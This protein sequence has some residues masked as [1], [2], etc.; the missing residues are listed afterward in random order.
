MQHP[1]NFFNKMVSNFREMRG[2]TSHMYASNDIYEDAEES[3]A[4][5]VAR[6]TIMKILENE[7]YSVD[8]K[9]KLKSML[10]DI[11]KLKKGK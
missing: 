4:K 7:Q 8:L 10:V 9:E 1:Q 3:L 6:K 11:K 5:I 2:D